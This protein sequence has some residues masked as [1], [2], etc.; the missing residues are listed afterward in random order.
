MR[1]SLPSPVVDAH[2]LWVDFYWKAWELAFRN[3]YEPAPGSGFVSRFID[4]AFNENIFLWD[5]CFMTLFADVAYPLVPGISTLDNFYAKQY[6][7]G[8]ICREIR[9]ATGLEFAP[10]VNAEHLPLFSRWGFGVAGETTPVP[11]IYSG[12]P[13]PVPNPRLTLDALDH[14]ILSW[15]EMEHLRLTGD[16]SRLGLVWEPLV[17]Y[18]R[19]LQKYLRQGNGLYMT[20]WASMDNS[21]RNPFL[22]RGGTAVDTSSE[23]VL[24]ARHLAEMAGILGKKVESDV[25]A[26]EAAE[27]SRTIAARMWD[28]QSKFFYDLTLEGR[29]TP[30]KTVAAF[31]TLLAGV[32]SPGQAQFL[33]AELENPA[34]FGR[35]HPVPTCSADTSGY[36]SN[37]GYWR[38]AVWAPTNTMVIKGLENY[39]YRDLARKIALKHLEISA[40]VFEDT[41][42]IW[43]NYAPDSALPGR[44]DDG[45][46]V[47]RD[48]VGWSGIGPI[49]YLL[50][51]GIGLEPDALGNRLV[52]RSDLEGKSGCI[53]YRFNGHVASL[54]VEKDG[55]L[56][57][58]MSVDSDGDFG[59]TFIGMGRQR[60]LTIKRGK[61][62]FSW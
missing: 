1:T 31:W 48:F 60:N 11:I 19:A 26:A 33:A 47:Q 43:E 3:F 35:L 10:W 27:L 37:G 42:T 16:R 8:E 28:E 36:N 45:S 41:G 21:P 2:P 25:F 53:R 7:D 29:R 49:L 34:T 20:D 56:P 61:N 59:L 24:F 12:R 51:Y 39:G 57:R 58:H 30:V 5:S 55:P 46:L 6:S 9:R 32:A 62:E 38:G 22:D 23:M 15:A 52:W 17:R 18:Y 44:H 4:A 13:A 40:K 50:R 54:I 14:P